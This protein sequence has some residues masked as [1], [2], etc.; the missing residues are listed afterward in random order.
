MNLIWLDINSSYSHSSLALPAIEACRCGDAYEWGVVSGTIGSD[1]YSLTNELYA[2]QPDIVAATLWLFNHDIVMRIC[3]RISLLM[4]EVR[5][6]LGGPEFNG[7]NESFLRQHPYVESVFRGEGERGF[8]D[9][10]SDKSRE[11]IVGLCYLDAD[12]IY[13]DNGVARVAD[14]EMLPLPE[15]SRF[16]NFESPFVQIETSRG[17][18][19]SCA[20]C[21]SGGDKPIRSK[22][23]ETMAERIECVRG[24]G[25]KDIRILDRTFNYSVARAREM[26][27][28]FR[29]YPDMNFHLEIHPALLSDEL[30]AQLADMPNG[31]L[32]L[33]AGMQ[34]LDDRVIEASGRI[35]TNE[36]AVQGLSRLCQ[37]DNFETHADLIAGLPHYTLSQ[38]FS[39]VKQLAQIGAGEIQL[40]LLK[41]LPGTKMRNE[42]TTLGIKYATAPPYEVLQTPDI[43]PFELDRARLLSRL[44]D[45]YY[46]SVALRETTRQLI[47]DEESFLC[48]FL[49]YLIA[50]NK[51]EQ[52]ISL[53]KRVSMLF[54]FC[55][56]RM[57]HHLDQVS[58]L[59]IKC[60]FS[61]RRE[62]AGD[63]SKA[64]ELPPYIERQHNTHYYTWRG[65]N[66][67]Y[68]ICYDRSVDHS[69]PRFV[70]L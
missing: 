15:S 17:C 66:S 67:R 40:E 70:E 38:I 52:P 54:K 27:N 41:L 34:S 24:H 30:C 58:I 31:V 8:H 10:I 37:M 23:V 25:V 56:D 36:K 57:P 50:A 39:D 68:L 64:T 3:Q 26:L 65:D 51:L 14:F 19:N 49:D 33:E 20:F 9:V 59:W 16:F 48:D 63:I 42:S 45:R 35:G 62:E 5:I 61:L 60:G 28:L 21:V 6:I 11:Q 32:H 46:N 13:R 55:R 44:L 4:P 22:S 43:T 29:S 12:S 1:I 69:K 7:D 18:F 47:V 53:E 2:A